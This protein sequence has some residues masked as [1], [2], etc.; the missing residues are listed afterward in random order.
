[1]TQKNQ[2]QDLPTNPQLASMQLPNLPPK[3]ATPQHTLNTQGLMCPEPVMLLHK[4]MRE[5]SSD[6]LIYMTAS[7]PTTTRDIPNFCRHLGHRLIAYQEQINPNHLSSP[8]A[9]ANVYH[10]WICKK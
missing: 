3:D 4:T 5:A 10:Y 1:M 6:E 8:D 7:D 9:Y 2:P